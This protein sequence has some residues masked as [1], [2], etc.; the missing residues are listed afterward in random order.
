M[1]TA[2]GRPEEVR[3][4]NVSSAGELKFVVTFYDLNANQYPSEFHGE[5]RVKQVRANFKVLDLPPTLQQLHNNP[6]QPR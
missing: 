5:F 4:I 2:C 3:L 1:R 6:R